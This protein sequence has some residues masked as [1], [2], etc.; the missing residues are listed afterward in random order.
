M[1][2]TAS[3]RAPELEEV[4][5]DKQ[6]GKLESDVAH[7]QTDVASIKTDLR[8]LRGEAHEIRK[9]TAELRLDMLKGFA[10]I[11]DS[12]WKDRIWMLLMLGAVLGTMLSVMARGFQWI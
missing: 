2:K 3:A 1:R 11:K 9:S 5:V 6:M 7:I 8:D 12:R 10:S 4:E